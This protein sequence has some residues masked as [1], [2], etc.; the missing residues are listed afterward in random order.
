M[1]LLGDNYVLAQEINPKR[2]NP[3]DVEAIDN[4]ELNHKMEMVNKGKY[5]YGYVNPVGMRS[6]GR[7]GNVLTLAAP[8][9]APLI[10][11]GIQ[12]LLKKIH[13][14]KKGL[15]MTLTTKQNN[16]VNKILNQ[17]ESELKYNMN[18]HQYSSGGALMKDIFKRTKHGIKNL[19]KELL[20]IGLPIL[21]KYAEE[22]LLN[23]HGIGLYGSK[24]GYKSIMLGKTGGALITS[25]HIKHG[26]ILH[27]MLKHHLQ[28][29][30]KG[31]GIDDESL[32]EIVNEILD[33]DPSMDE[34][35]TYERLAQ[36]TQGGSFF[37]KLKNKVG[38]LIKQAARSETVKNLGSQLKEVGKKALNQ[39]I[40]QYGNKLINK[41]TNNKYV[42]K[43]EDYTGLN[44][45]DLANQSKEFGKSKIN[46]YIDTGYNY[47]LNTLQNMEEE[48]ENPLSQELPMT[49]IGYKKK[50]QGGQWTIKLERL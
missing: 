3:Q 31:Y 2:L 47:G 22:H 26:H 21:Q 18:N 50:K 19:G 33:S 10:H 35:L 5:G 38:S 12:Y 23:Q 15:G 49:G 43:I 41:A 6:F 14:K 25:G 30:T 32:T 4:N 36:S 13:G 7:G 27:P 11:E 20:K 28:N 17:L 44:A 39:T 24:K 40:D 34:V 45:K 42:K 37:S 8:V 1:D 16:K 29:A 48:S 9:L 46:N